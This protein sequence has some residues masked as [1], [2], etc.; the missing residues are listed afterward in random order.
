MKS[1]YPISKKH[2]DS[3]MRVII[4]HYASHDTSCELTS[5]VLYTSGAIPK[6]VDKDRVVSV[7][8][9]MGYIKT[10]WL[11]SVSGT[12][13]L[14]TPE[15]NTYFERKLDHDREK[16]IETIRYIITTAIAVAAIVIALVA[17][18]AQLGLLELPRP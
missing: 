11:Q 9:D 12:I 2:R 4:D 3:A 13:I 7:L 18:F 16:K 10:S 15:G 14:L 6:T 1:K 5:D 17:L 8:K